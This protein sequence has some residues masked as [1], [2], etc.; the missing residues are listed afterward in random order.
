LECR[1]L[2]GPLVV[3]ILL[4]MAREHRKTLTSGSCGFTLVEVLV[5]VSIIGVL[6]ALLFPA[7]QAARE[8]ARKTTCANTTRTKRFRRGTFRS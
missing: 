3:G 7:I 2:L 4:A 1:A 6:V 8:A 5:V